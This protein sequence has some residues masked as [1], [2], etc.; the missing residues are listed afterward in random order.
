M[1]E[2]RKCG[3]GAYRSYARR[4]QRFT[5]F[6]LIWRHEE[7]IRFHVLCIE[8]DPSDVELAKEALSHTCE[9]VEYHIVVTVEEEHVL[10]E[11]EQKEPE[12]H[13]DGFPVAEKNWARNFKNDPELRP[14]W[15]TCPVIFISSVLFPR[16]LN[17][18]PSTCASA[19]FFDKPLDFKN[20]KEIFRKI[21]HEWF[22][23]LSEAKA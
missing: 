2:S 20:F 8:D 23:P 13:S 7:E 19:L 16:A 1:G 5:V 10:R 6:F 22:I 3:V 12:H 21:C 15:H 17:T 9:E 4:A 11:C 18:R 14:R